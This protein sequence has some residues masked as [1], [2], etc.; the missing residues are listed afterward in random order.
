[1]WVG[2]WGI[3]SFGYGVPLEVSFPTS[4]WTVRM[5]KKCARGERWRKSAES[6]LMNFRNFGRVYLMDG[7]VGDAEFL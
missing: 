4:Y 3:L 7:K 5:L 1:M 2:G 6:D